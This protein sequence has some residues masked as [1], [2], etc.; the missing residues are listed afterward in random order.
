MNFLKKKNQILKNCLEKI[1]NNKN[2]LAELITS[3]SGLSLK[4]SL[5]EVDRAISCLDFSIKLIKK[6][7]NKNMTDEFI[8][9]NKRMPKLEVLLEPM[10]LAI[11]ITPFNHP[12]NL[13]MHKLAPSIISGTAMVLKPSEKTPLTAIK[14]HEILIESGL[15][16]NHINLVHGFPPK[17]VV[18]QLI[19][20]P[21]IDLVSVTGGVS[22]GK[23]IESK[24]IESGNNF[25]KYMPELGGNATFVV[26]NDCDI[27]LATNLALA[28]FENSGQ[29]CTAIRRILLH[30]DIYDIFID[31]FVEKTKSLKVGDPMDPMTDIGTVISSEQVDLIQKR[32]LDAENEGA[33]IIT[34][35]RRNGAQ[36]EPTIIKDVSIDS[37]LVKRETFGP[38]A[39]IIKIDNLDQAINYIEEDSFGLASAIVTSDERKARKLYNKICVGQ[40][41]WNGP[42]GYR[43]E[44]APFGGF[45]VSGNGEK[46]GIVMMTKA[47]QRVRTF[48]E[49]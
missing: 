39:S 18:D 21:K 29:R 19:T 48:Y 37:E 40:F 11:G 36:L 6:A 12:L 22:I 31:S 1:S 32:I 49:H 9:D 17:K 30:K 43:T 26:M 28:S 42:P 7:I 35:N 10:D 13:V 4:H 14:L 47:L 23:Y 20:F 2:T 8:F 45:G 16:L 25:K 41:S 44:V 24:M 38:V 33:K 46:E 15:P 27:E 5:H 3:E 34:G